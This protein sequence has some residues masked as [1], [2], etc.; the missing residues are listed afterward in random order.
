MQV[1]SVDVVCDSFQSFFDRQE[2]QYDIVV[3]CLR[4][5]HQSQAYPH[6]LPALRRSSW[7]QA[8]IK[9]WLHCNAARS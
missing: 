5:N 6:V 7:Y 2:K 9:S 8:C 3:S 1:T 4:H